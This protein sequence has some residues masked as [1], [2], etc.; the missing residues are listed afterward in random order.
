[1][2]GGQFIGE[3]YPPWKDETWRLDAVSQDS[4]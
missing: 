2:N 1:M 3:G 4:R